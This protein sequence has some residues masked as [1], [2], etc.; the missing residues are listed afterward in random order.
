M[1]VL[2][3]CFRHRLISIQAKNDADLGF[4]RNLEN[5]GQIEVCSWYLHITVMIKRLDMSSRGYGGY[6]DK[7]TFYFFPFSICF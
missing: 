2:L 1:N 7:P 3:L 4:L 5:G 6:K